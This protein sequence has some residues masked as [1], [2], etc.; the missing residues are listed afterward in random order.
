MAN[1]LTTGTLRDRDFKSFVE[2]PS[3]GEGY[4]A[5][6]VFSGQLSSF[7]PSSNV[8]AITTQYPDAITEIYEYRVGGI[9]GAI[10]NTVTVVYTAADK[11]LIQSVSRV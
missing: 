6:E 5:R 10:E 3:R 4:T 8:D 11:E 9:A 7:T 2:S 1:S